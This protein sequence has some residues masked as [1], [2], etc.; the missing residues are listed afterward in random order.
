MLENATDFHYNYIKIFIMSNYILGISSIFF[1]ACHLYA[2]IFYYNSLYNLLYLYYIGGVII[3]IG[4]HFSEISVWKYGDRFIMTVGSLVNGYYIYEYCSYKL[5]PYCGIG[6]ASI[7]YFAS[8]ITNNNSYHILCHGI[9]TITH[10]FIILNA[11][12]VKKL[13]PT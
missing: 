2:I 12:S 8:K 1:G 5:L 13:A 4:N 3:S 11:N 6:L 7:S 10:I 9:I